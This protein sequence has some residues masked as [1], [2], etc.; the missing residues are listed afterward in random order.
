MYMYPLLQP[1][2]SRLRSDFRLPNKLEQKS[3]KKKQYCSCSVEFF[4]N[5]FLTYQH[6]LKKT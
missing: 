6:K 1:L 4:V 2:P 5:E 3:T